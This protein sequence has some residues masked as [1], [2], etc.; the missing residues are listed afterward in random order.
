MTISI[1]CNYVS[2]YIKKQSEYKNIPV[3]AGI[4]SFAK[5]REGVLPCTI[6]DDNLDKAM[7]VIKDLIREI[8]NPEIPFE[9]KE[10]EMYN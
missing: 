4:W 2:I 7:E 3:E 5:V 8:L 9:E 10:H 1:Y 6:E